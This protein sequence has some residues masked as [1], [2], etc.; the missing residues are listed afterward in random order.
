MITN[1]PIFIQLT[2]KESG[3]IFPVDIADIKTITISNKENFS[4]IKLKSKEQP[5]CVK[6]SFAKIYA[7]TKGEV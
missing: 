2:E 5:I 4:Y 6:E 1:K 7:L 3:K